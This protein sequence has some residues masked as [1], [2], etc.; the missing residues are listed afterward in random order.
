VLPTAEALGQGV[1]GGEGGGR[2]AEVVRPE[3]RPLI[4]QLGAALLPG[5][6][7]DFGTFYDDVVDLI[8]LPPV[9]REER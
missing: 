1:L 3:A 2:Q 6:Q 7:G 4:R 5:V 9:W 8:A